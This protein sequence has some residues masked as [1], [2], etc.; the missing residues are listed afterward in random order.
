MVSRR[1]WAAIRDVTAFASNR[2]SA[3]VPLWR[4]STAPA[5]GHEL[6]ATVARAAEA[7][8][9]YDWGGGLIWLLVPDA[10]AAAA[11]AV[12]AAVGTLGGHATLI[13]APA[14]LRSSIEPFEPQPAGLAALTKRVKQG[15]D[16]KSVLNPSRMWAGV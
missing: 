16:P 3:D 13:R 6:V 14:A 12:R 15:F 10:P 4:I 9:L 7:Q 11:G 5:S 2:G 1:L 8:A